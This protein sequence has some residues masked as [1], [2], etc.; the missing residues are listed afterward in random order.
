MLRSISVL[1]IVCIVGFCLASPGQ[2]RLP[3]TLNFENVTSANVIQ[4]VSEASS[5]EKEVEFGDFDN[6]GDLDVVIASAQSDFGTRKNKLYRNDGGVMLEISGGSIIPGFSSQDVSRNAF[7]RDYTGDGWLDIIIVNDANT[8]GDGGRTKFYVNKQVAGV[9][10]H[11]EEQGIIYLQMAGGAACSAQSIDFDG[12]NGFDLYLGNYAG[13]AQ[14]TMYFNDGNGFLTEVTKSHVPTEND[15]TVDVSS[16]DLN[17]DGQ[18]DLLRSDH[19]GSNSIYYNN[20]LNQGSGLGDFKYGADGHAGVFLLGEAGQNENSM[21]GA[22]FDGDG[23]V[24]IYW[25]NRA[26]VSDKVLRNIGNDGDNMAMFEEVHLPPQVTDFKSVK[27]TVMDLNHD[28]KIDVFVMGN[29]SRPTVLRNVSWDDHIAFV[30]W[31]P[32]PAFP[33]GSLHRGWHAAAFHVDDDEWEDI[34]LGGWNDDHL[35]RNVDSNELDE[36]E[37]DVIDGKIQLPAVFNQDPV[38]VSGTAAVG[39]P[40]SY[41]LSGLGFGFISVVLNGEDD[42]EL[43]FFDTDGGLVLKVDRGTFGI[44]EAAQID[45]S[46]IGSISVVVLESGGGDCEGDANGDGL[47]DPLDSGFVLA[48]FGCSIGTGD[49]GCDA[50]DQNGDRAVDPLDVGFVLARFGDCEGGEAGSY[51]LEILARD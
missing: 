35:F 20:N 45:A 37:L 19:G 26:G 4:T 47:V 2:A 18:I 48:R 13:P 51:I 40:D 42:L 10:D 33:N 3:G 15:Y 41:D 38:A 1:A 44:E 49:E 29:D 22:D 6:D 32:A 11:F 39:E 27:A 43:D 50:A 12:I 46:G 25:V 21:E 7:L 9:F 8:G 17:G 30:D 16:A 14:D 31:T 5:N 24:D 36:T 23:R 28:G 34:F